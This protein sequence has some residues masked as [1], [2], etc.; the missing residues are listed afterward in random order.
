MCQA[1]DLRIQFRIGQCLIAGGQRHRRWCPLNLRGKQ[2]SHGGLSRIGS[3][4]V[5]AERQEL[6]TL[7]RS[8]QRQFRECVLGVLNHVCQQAAETG[9]HA[10]HGGCVEQ[11]GVVLPDQQHLT[12]FRCIRLPAA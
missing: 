10:F 1:V 3:G 7:R 11:V 4:R 12:C 6:L 9:Q 5:T 8:Q 2:L